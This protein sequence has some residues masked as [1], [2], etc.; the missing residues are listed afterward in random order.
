[1][2]GLLLK[3]VASSDMLELSMVGFGNARYAKQP[4]IEKIILSIMLEIAIIELLEKE[5][6]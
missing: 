1:M 6:T 2:R 3:S 4:T 5:K